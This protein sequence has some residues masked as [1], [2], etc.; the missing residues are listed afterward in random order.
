MYLML[1]EGLLYSGFVT[2]FTTTAMVLNYAAPL[3]SFWQRLLN[4]LTIPISGLMSARFILHVREWHDRDL[5]EQFTSTGAL[6]SGIRFQ[7]PQSPED[8][9][10]DWSRE[11]LSYIGNRSVSDYDQSSFQESTT[12]NRDIDQS[13]IAGPSRIRP[14]DPSIV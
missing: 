10:S 4:A 1:K 9:D 3:G 6:A 12:G 14:N 7:F 2:L 13:S 5:H 8:S 11:D